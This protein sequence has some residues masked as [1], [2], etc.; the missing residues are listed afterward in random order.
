MSAVKKSDTLALRGWKGENMDK[1]MGYCTNAKV[2]YIGGGVG[3][4]ERIKVLS[5]THSK[6]WLKKS[7][8]CKNITLEKRGGNCT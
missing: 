2:A 8:I 1:E 4:E 5:C 3:V 6:L 7:L